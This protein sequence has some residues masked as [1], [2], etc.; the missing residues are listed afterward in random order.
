[1]KELLKEY[2]KISG[3]SM[4]ETINIENELSKVLYPNFGNL[5]FFINL[6]YHL[7]EK[8]RNFFQKKR[9]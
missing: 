6:L 2:S 7:L 9:L 3:S 5:N 8:Q 4:E 1:L